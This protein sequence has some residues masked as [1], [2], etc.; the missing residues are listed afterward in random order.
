MSNLELSVRMKKML[1]VSLT[2]R[3]VDECSK[4]MASCD[5]DLIEHRMDFMDRIERLD[6]IYDATKVPIIATCRALQDSGHFEGN[7]ASR[8]GHL[9]EAISAGASYVDIELDTT[10]ELMNLVRKEAARNNSKLIVSKH[11]SDSTPDLP[12]LLN[13]LDRLTI[14]GADVMKLV[15][16][17]KTMSDCGRVLQL[18]Y[19]KSKPARPMIAFAM[20]DLGKFTRVSALFLGAP[21]MYVS[22]DQGEQA[23]PGQIT[24]TQM[25]TLLEVL[26]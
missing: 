25:R 17:P 16:T 23:A 18:Y 19:V 15:T 6:A 3:S 22:Q 14:S 26:E 10:S 8:I 5:A 12:E 9:I 20:G 4:A 7:E 24:V 11:F 2:E 13:V 1:C 21:F